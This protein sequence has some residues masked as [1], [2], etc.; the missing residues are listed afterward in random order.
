MITRSILLTVVLASALFGAGCQTTAVIPFSKEQAIARANQEAM[1]SMPE[2]G[3]RQARID[4]ITAELTT[5][6]EA[7]QRMGG[8]RGTGGY[9]P[10]QTANSPVWWVNVRGYFQY[11][12]MA[13]PPNPAPVC[14]ADERHFI[15]DA[16]TGEY[17]GGRMPNTRCK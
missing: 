9:R 4:G 1:Q 10:G 14:E 2:V 12:G 16:Q 15:Y 13:A 3:I 7:D 11:E 6:G 5:L 17:V 8:Q